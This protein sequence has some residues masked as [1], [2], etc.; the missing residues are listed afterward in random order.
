MLSV[1]SEANTNNMKN[2]DISLSLWRERKSII[3]DTETKTEEE[4]DYITPE[5]TSQTMET[6]T[7][8]ISQTANSEGTPQIKTESLVKEITINKPTPFTGNQ[9]RVQGFIQECLSYLLKER[10]FSYLSYCRLD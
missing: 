8:E 9:T 2:P 1:L 7:G 4:P 3:S 10:S 6:T 5:E